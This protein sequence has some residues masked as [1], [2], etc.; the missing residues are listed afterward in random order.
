MALAPLHGYLPFFAATD[1]ASYFLFV[2]RERGDQLNHRQLQN[3][4]YYGQGFSLFSPGKLLFGEPIEARHDGPVVAVVARQYSA[5][6]DRPIELAE[7]FA[8]RGDALVAS[9]LSAERVVASVYNGFRQVGCAE[10]TE[11]IMSERPFCRAASSDGVVEP[12]DLLHWWREYVD[13]ERASRPRPKPMRLN[14]YLAQHPDFAARLRQ[15][16]LGADESSQ[17]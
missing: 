4:L 17:R 11:R 2:A 7:S 5:S 15:A 12:G 16:G 14:T 6:G 3:L 13:H 8:P 10:L 9:S 1:A